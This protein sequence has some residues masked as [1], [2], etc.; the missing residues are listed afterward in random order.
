MLILPKGFVTSLPSPHM[1]HVGS[2]DG[3][4][5]ALGLGLGSDEMID[6]DADGAEL[7]TQ[8]LEQNSSSMSEGTPPPPLLDCKSFEQEEQR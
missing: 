6:G 2:L 8:I 1:K 4:W 5:L 3:I 7:G